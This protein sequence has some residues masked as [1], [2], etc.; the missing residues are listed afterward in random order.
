MISGAGFK[1]TTDGEIKMIQFSELPT[2][3]HTT[4]NKQP[5]HHLHVTAN[6]LF[7]IVVCIIKGNRDSA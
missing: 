1:N 7:N 6:V 4:L 5:V 3:F 2:A